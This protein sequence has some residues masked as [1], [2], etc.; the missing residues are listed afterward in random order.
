MW[1]TDDHSCLSTS[2]GDST[3]CMV[4]QCQKGSNPS[5]LQFIRWGEMVVNTD[6]LPNFTFMMCAPLTFVQWAC[7][8]LCLLV[9][10]D[11]HNVYENWNIDIHVTSKCQCARSHS[12]WG[13]VG[14]TMHNTHN[15]TC[16]IKCSFQLSLFSDCS[17]V[18]CHA[19]NLTND[20]MGGFN[21]RIGSGGMRGD[22]SFPNS[23]VH[24]YEFPFTTET[25]DC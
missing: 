14:N 8:C 1:Q 7:I 21:D 18:L 20:S 11:G 3:I 15:G 10:R 25:C 23:P 6:S 24:K 22:S 13:N 5:L 12:L 17:A 16:I 19:K 2:N 4:T 9:C